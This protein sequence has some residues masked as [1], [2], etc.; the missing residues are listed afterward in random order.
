VS[1]VTAPKGEATNPLS[2]ADLEAKFN[3]A[4]RLVATA[5]QR[6]QV[7]T[8]MND[9]RAGSLPALTASLAEITLRGLR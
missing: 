6:D 4:T 3:A 9:A 8:A 2:W 7:V 1:D 5:A